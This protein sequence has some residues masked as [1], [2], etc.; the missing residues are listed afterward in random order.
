MASHRVTIQERRTPARPIPSRVDALV[1][2]FK[3]CVFSFRRGIKNAV[4][5]PPRLP[6]VPDTT[7]FAFEIASSRTPLWAEGPASERALQRGKVH[8]LR[9][10]AR[11]LDQTFIRADAEFSFWRQLGKPTRAK[12]FVAGRMLQEGCLVPS[13]GGGLCQLSNALYDVALK[14]DCDIVERHPH[15]RMVPGS[16][17]ARGRDATVAW[18]YIDLRFVSRLPI[19]LRVR[20]EQDDLVVGLFAKKDVIIRQKTE[21]LQDEQAHASSCEDCGE[22]SCFRHHRSDS[23]RKGR[24]AFLVDGYSPEF[25][26]YLR[27]IM[28]AK[29]V[30]C[31]P[32]DGKR[33][34]RPAYAWDTSGYARVVSAPITV[35]G[36]SFASRR[37][38]E[39]G[40][41]RQSALLLS[42]DALASQFA[43]ALT[44]DVTEIVVAQ[45]F[46]PF[47]WRNGDLGGRRFSV[48]A[49]R[50][51]IESLQHQL[52]KAAALHRDCRTLSDFRA[53]ERLVEDERDAL[54]AADA[55]ITPHAAIAALFN[56]RSNL[57]DWQIPRGRSRTC[58]ASSRRIAFPGPVVG[59]KGAFELRL[60]AQELGLDVVTLGSELEG[61]N[62]WQNVKTIRSDGP[63]WLDEVA[64]VVQ[65]A[66]VEE[67]PRRLLEA[68]AAGVPVIATAACGIG[69]RPGVTL[70]PA[71]DAG[72]LKQAIESVLD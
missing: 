18:N 56:G 20:V 65:P 12:G 3:S 24:A 54:A 60:A 71:G 7:L 47:L 30:L 50:L 59:R 51:P 4:A 48:L 49:S 72:A 14:A 32:L 9:A 61:P 13:I 66:F 40:A 68:V 31:L 10:A 67:R 28:G 62:F 57:L 5:D 21:P 2:R 69:E 26:S 53:P 35:L 63:G 19:M 22:R 36:R 42:A 70:V 16:A 39:Q 33:W 37:L 8:N 15:S 11:R 6:L 44:D 41:A 27:S 46:L 64:A 23:A 17:S 52:D 29:D 34:G 55:I 25:D 43:R 45:S 38:S 1:F 58:K